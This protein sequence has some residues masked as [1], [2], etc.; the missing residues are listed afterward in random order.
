MGTGTLTFSDA[1]NG[2]FAYT[3]KGI[4]QTKAITR[5]VFGPCRS[6]WDANHIEAR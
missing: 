2:S 5:E 3:V 6:L 1:N 4:S